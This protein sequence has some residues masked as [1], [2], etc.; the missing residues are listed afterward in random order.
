M[1]K[2]C[3]K[4]KLEKFTSEFHKNKSEKDGYGHYC[5]QCN[6]ARVNK[7]NKENYDK[8]KYTRDKLY[9][10]HGI[11]KQKFEKIL[12]DQ[13]NKCKI[14]NNELCLSNFK[15]ITIDHDHNCCSGT[16][17]C[18]RCIR[19]LLCSVCNKGLGMFYDDIELLKSAIL[20]LNGDDR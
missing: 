16:Y 9:K 12:E 6:N 7:Y 3:S 20:Y 5:K 19:G 15:Q 13:N 2:I 10:R 18:G 4:C 8:I 1:K 17:S 11:D 14:C